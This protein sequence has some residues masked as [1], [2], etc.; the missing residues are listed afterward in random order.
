MDDDLFGSDG[1]NTAVVIGVIVLALI[2]AEIIFG[3]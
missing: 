1:R 3:R 2:V